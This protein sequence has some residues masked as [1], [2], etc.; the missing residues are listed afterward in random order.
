MRPAHHLSETPGRTRLDRGRAETYA[1]SGE[2]ESRTDRA[3]PDGPSYVRAHAQR[4]SD[5]E[6][7]AFRRDQ[8][9]QRITRRTRKASCQP[10][11]GTPPAGTGSSVSL[12]LTR[13]TVE[14]GVCGCRPF[15]FLRKSETAHRVPGPFLLLTHSRSPRCRSKIH[16]LLTRSNRMGIVLADE[17]YTTARG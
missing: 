9:L 2:G 14:A 16:L 1:R 4:G 10:A 12:T 15:L 11:F 6:R 17:N 5:G 3:H 7:Q 8:G 13:S